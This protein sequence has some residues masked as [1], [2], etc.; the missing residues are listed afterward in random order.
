[1]R[2][3]TKILFTATLVGGLGAATAQAEEMTLSAVNFVPNNNSFGQPF[4]EWVEKVNAEGEGLIQIDLKASG[5]MSPFQMGD[6]VKSGAVAMAN[7]PATFYQNL[8][9]IGDA[10]KHAQTAP[11][12]PETPDPSWELIND[13]HEEKVNARYLTA[14]GW[15]TPFHAYFRE[16]G[17]DPEKIRSLDWSGI[18]MRIT[19]VYRA[20]FNELGAELTQMK[21]ADVYTALERGTVDGYGWPIWDIQSFGWDEVTAYRVDPGFYTV[22]VGIIVNLDTWNDMSAEQQ[23]F[24]QKAA[25]EFAWNEYRSA[26]EK[27]AMWRERQ[28]ESGVEVIELE[29]EAREKY[30]DAAYAA[31]WAEAEKL[32]PENA[33]KLKPLISE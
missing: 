24:L 13:L 18:Q 3:T 20:F 22:T 28:K 25:W 14:W 11:Q 15:G 23:D 33:A 10:L 4:A 26:E 29:G 27:N 16:G 21:P 30:I 2:N 1:M 5:S 12:G 6:A 19:P 7:L 17:P 32:A 31:G 9:P 8:L